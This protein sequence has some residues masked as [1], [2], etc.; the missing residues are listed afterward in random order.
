MRLLPVL[1]ALPLLALQAHAQTAAAQQTAPPPATA[2]M[3]A[4]APAA[5]GSDATVHHRMSWQ[6]HF[7]QANLAHDGH[8]TLQEASGGYP[9]VARHFKEIDADKKGY[10]TEEDVTNWHKLQ[11]AMR[12]SNRGRTDGALRPRPA[13]H[14]GTSTPRPISTSTDDKML[15][16]TQPDVLPAG[17]QATTR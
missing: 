1:I 5:P 16:M 6:Q 17:Q 8:L 2:T 7:A 10:V 11:R 9:T 4:P 3:G 13:F 14:E 15:P 12:H